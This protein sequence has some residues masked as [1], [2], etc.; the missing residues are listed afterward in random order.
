MDSGLSRKPHEFH[1]HIQDIFDYADS[2]ATGRKPACQL[3]MLA[4]QRFYK[5]LERESEYL[6]DADKAIRFIE[7]TELLKHV[8]GKWASKRTSLKLEPWQKFIHGNLFGWVHKDTGLRRFRL[9][10][11][12][13]PRKSGKTFGVAVPIGLYMFTAENEFGAEIYCGANSESQAWEVFR[14]AKQLCEA[15]PALC[16]AFNIQVNARSIEARNGARFQPVIGKPGDGASPSCAIHDEY[17]EAADSSQFDTMSTGMGAREQGLQLVITTAGTNIESPCY[18]LERDIE[19]VLRGEV[20]ND[21]V[22]GLIFGIDKDD[23]WTTEES[24]IKANPNYGISVGADFLKAA[25]KYAI[26]NS[27][28]QNSFKTKHLNV[29][30]WAKSAYFNA[31]KWL[32]LGDTSLKIE[33]FKDDE[34]FVSLDLA[35]IHD[36]SSIVTVFRRVI[37]GQKHYYV[38]AKNYLPEDTISSDEIPELKD[39]YQKWYIDGH[40]LAGGE[41]EMDLSVITNEVIAMQQAGYNIVEV[42]HDP[43]LGFL[44]AKELAEVG[45][46]PVEMRQHGTYLGPGMREIEAAIASNRIHHDGNPVTSWCIGNVL[47]KEFSNGGLMPAKENKS[48]KIDAAVGLIMG[49]GRAMLGDYENID[50]FL[51]DPITG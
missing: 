37:G 26:Q 2:V 22:F 51:N 44:I 35:K 25:Q 12:K 10:Y 40:L 23:D 4:C 38:F 20:E 17:H 11:I 14:P 36:L 28:K 21:E 49:V 19:R 8:K 46:T 15:T 18:Q 9:A 13:A 30:C 48:N 7:F 42:P 39:K 5:D 3:E 47:G 29:W 1:P 32:E 24:L 50:D 6:F 41:A 33:D 31:Q 34:C 16:K 27:S 43:H 45:L